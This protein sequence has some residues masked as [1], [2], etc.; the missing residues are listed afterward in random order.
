MYSS[1]V[2]SKYSEPALS[3]Q[4]SS[5]LCD[6]LSEVASVDDVDGIENLL[7]RNFQRK[8]QVV[9]KEHMILPAKRMMYTALRKASTGRGTFANCSRTSVRMLEEAEDR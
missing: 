7:R 3:S 5:S 2:S 8:Q 1:S 4:E 9:M 6:S